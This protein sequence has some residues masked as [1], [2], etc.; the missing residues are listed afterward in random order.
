MPNLP[1]EIITDI[2]TRLPVKSLLRFRC[3]SKPWCTLIDSRSFTKLHLNRSLQTGSNHYIIL[4]FLAIYSIDLNCLDSATLIRPPFSSSDISNSCNGLVLVLATNPYI[5]N[6]F[7]RKFRELPANSVDYPVGVEVVSAYETFGFAY[8]SEN[9][10]YF[11]LRVV[12][13]RGPHL[14]WISSEA[15]VYSSKL[16]SWRRIGDFPY[17]LPYKRVWGAHLNGVLHTAVRN[18][19]MGWSIMG[20]DVSNG[21]HSAIPIP[22]LPGAA[23][24]DG[25][26]EFTVEVLGG[27]LC[28]VCP[29]RKDRTDVWIM[30]E[31]RVKESWT[32]LLSVAPP[33][34]EPYYKISPLAF[35]KDGREVLLNHDDKQLMWYNLKKKTVRSVSVDGMPFVFYGDVCVSSLVRPD[36]LEGEDDDDQEK[37]LSKISR[38]RDDFLSEGFKLVL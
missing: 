20:F 17:Q 35:S 1:P 9:D 28:L 2:L 15:K 14:D 11:V 13:F 26:A 3:V 30:K 16:N 23:S 12:E 8:D 37:R 6:P 19:N 18:S 27:C 25:Y 29:R 33:V 4:G 24:S 38:K 32:M 7:T 5:W 22:D 21:M 36:G 31:Y 34:V 10:D